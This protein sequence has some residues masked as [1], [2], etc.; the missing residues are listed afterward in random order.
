MPAGPCLQGLFGNLPDGDL[1][2]FIKFLNAR[3]FRK[4]LSTAKSWTPRLD[5]LQEPYDEA[6]QVYLRIRVEYHI[7]YPSRLLP[8]TWRIA[9][10][11]AENTDQ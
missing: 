4:V 7:S 3:E 8:Q 11:L 5:K 2:T 6:V 1:H 10:L 9:K